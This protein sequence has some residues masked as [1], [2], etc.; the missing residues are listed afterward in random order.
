MFLQLWSCARTGHYRAAHDHGRRQR[1]YRPEMDSLDERCVLS[2]HVVSDFVQSV[3]AAVA[4]NGVPALVAS[5]IPRPK[6]APSG[7]VVKAASPALSH[8]PGAGLSAPNS[9]TRST[10]NSLASSTAPTALSLSEL[11]PNPFATPLTTTDPPVASAPPSA[12]S[13]VVPFGPT[14]ARR[15]PDHS[16]SRCR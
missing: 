11:S 16:G 3:G 9:A 7:A 6:P 12:Q 1:A 4:V 10:G 13:A 2:A 15:P 8:N 14:S 5:R